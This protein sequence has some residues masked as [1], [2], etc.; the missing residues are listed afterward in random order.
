MINF[1]IMWFLAQLKKID[2]IVLHFDLMDWNELN[3]GSGEDISEVIL[4]RESCSPAKNALDLT[5]V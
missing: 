3:S 4:I 2:P 5:N 1:Y